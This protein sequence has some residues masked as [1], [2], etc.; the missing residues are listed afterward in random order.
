M[1]TDIVT[2]FGQGKEWIKELE[3]LQKERFDL[4]KYK[5]FLQELKGYTVSIYGWQK[6]KLE[7]AGMLY[8]VLD[9]RVLILNC[10]AFC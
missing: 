10:N 2:S 5:K 9:G 1:I 8:S 4:E 3:D 6:E 7:E